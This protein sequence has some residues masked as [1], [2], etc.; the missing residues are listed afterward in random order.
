MQANRFLARCTFTSLSAAIAAFAVI[1][2]KSG[3]SR[4][5]SDL[6]LAMGGQRDVCIGECLDLI[7][8][9]NRGNE[10]V[11][12]VLTQIDRLEISYCWPS[13]AT[14]TDNRIALVEL[15]DG[16]NIRI[17]VHS[18]DDRENMLSVHT[19]YDIDWHRGISP[20]GSRFYGLGTVFVHYLYEESATDEF[21]ICFQ[22]N[23]AC[24]A[25]PPNGMQNGFASELR[26]EVTVRATELARSPELLRTAK[27]KDYSFDVIQE[28]TKLLEMTE[29]TS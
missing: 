15:N 24:R 21:A 13:G 27:A 12:L 5:G 17:G 16:W 20:S 23:R 6:L 22:T 1:L 19:A 29:A 7:R 4:R 28:A 8:R 25:C 11:Q 2:W 18:R 14:S 10:C 3:V 26:T 9:A